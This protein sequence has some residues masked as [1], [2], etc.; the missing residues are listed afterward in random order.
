MEPARVRTATSAE[1]TQLVHTLVAAFAADPVVR[2]C[3]P[4]ARQY[5]ESMPDFTL[6]FGG[7]AFAHQ[8]AHCTENFSGA[9]LWLPPG[10][11]PNEEAVGEIVENTVAPSIRA[12]LY[13][14][15]ERMASYH[16]GEPHWYLPMIGVDPAHQG[17]G[18]GAALLE[19]ALE[20]CDRDGCCAYLESTNPR[21]ITLY[22]RHGFEVLGEI[23]VGTSPPMV[24][25]LRTRR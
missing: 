19:Y 5:F 8:E 6:A 14:M 25:M 3:W 21:N 18:H 24:P 2:W 16:P 7:A 12:D 11:H 20:R 15:L 10:V 17:H 13:T 4:N 23:Q 22:Q 1:E 9:A